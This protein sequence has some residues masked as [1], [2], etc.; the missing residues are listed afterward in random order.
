MDE[1]LADV[2]AVR[3]GRGGGVCAVCAVVTL[4]KYVN[5]HSDAHIYMYMYSNVIDHV[6]GHVT[7]TTL[8]C[9][10]CE[11]TPTTMV[12]AMR[13]KVARLTIAGTNTLAIRSASR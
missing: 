10:S 13:V 2:I 9:G 12:Q 6:T 8:T 7:N 11:A 3:R 5:K 1:G 4:G